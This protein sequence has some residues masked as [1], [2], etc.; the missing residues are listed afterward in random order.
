ML[1]PTQQQFCPPF[2]HHLSVVLVFY[3]YHLV[4]SS[5][6]PW[7]EEYPLFTP[8]SVSR[9]HYSADVN[10]ILSRFQKK[11]G[12]EGKQMFSHILTFRARSATPTTKAFFYCSWCVQHTNI[13]SLSEQNLLSRKCRI[14][15]T[16]M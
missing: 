2:S 7:L 8:A 11:R 4:S 1:T 12:E 9:V 16:K 13:P 15:N 3:H 6:K 14:V 5:G 10:K